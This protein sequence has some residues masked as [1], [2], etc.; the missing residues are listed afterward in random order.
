M[1][2][3]QRLECNFSGFYQGGADCNSFTNGSNPS[4]RCSRPQQQVCREA[5]AET[6]VGNSRKTHWRRSGQA[7][8]RVL[9]LQQPV[10]HP[11][12]NP[13]DLEDLPVAQLKGTICRVR[14]RQHA[15]ALSITDQRLYDE[16]SAHHRNHNIPWL[17]LLRLVHHQDIAVENAN[18]PHRVA[19]GPHQEDRGGRA[20]THQFIER[21][22]W[23]LVV[24][25]RGREPTAALSAKLERLGRVTWAQSGMKSSVH[26]YKYCMDI[27]IGYAQLPGRVKLRGIFFL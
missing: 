12:A 19:P 18:V 20:D 26:F 13:P 6:G 27:Q 5:T 8:S 4:D 15:N 17:G 23:G 16:I 3:L 9:P 1:T 24:R 25:G 10:K 11:A 14:R 7:S 21:Q 22:I 2:P